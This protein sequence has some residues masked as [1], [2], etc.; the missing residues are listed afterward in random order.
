VIISG[1]AGRDYHNFLVYFKDN[2]KSEVVAFTQAQIPGIEKRSFPKELAGKL[3]KK[4][5][6][7]YPEEKLPELI[8]KYSV[9]EVVFSYSDVTHNQVMHLASIALANGADFR[10]LGPKSTMLKSKKLVISICAVRTGSGKSQTTRAI[11][12]ILKK[13]NKKVVSI[14]HPMP[15]GDLIKQKVQR[16][17]SEKDFKKY[18]TTIEEEE[19]YQPWI[20]NQ[21]VVYAGVDYKEILKQAE[22]EA[23][24]ILWDG[25]NNDLSFYHSDLHIV[26]ADPH[27]AGHELL[28]HPGETNFR[29]ADIILINKVD[30]ASKENIQLIKNNAKQYNS[31]AKIILARSDILVKSPEKIKNKRCLVVGDGPTLSH[32]GMSFGAGT[33]AVKK[34]QGKIV[35][36]RKYLVGSI[37]EAYKKYPN[38]QLELPAMG[39]SKK[40]IQELQTII[41]DTPCDL[42]VD[43]TPANLKRIIKTKKPI[44]EVNYELGNKAVKELTLMLKKLKFI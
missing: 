11:A 27:R 7:F 43:G 25:G 34:Y 37:K 39:Y 19:E 12:K 9:D 17:S 32:G 23:D 6:P 41:N 14:R 18:H 22:E 36:P 1:A 44:V 21:M 40:Q 8:K 2:P 5:I 10:L 31:K 20:D 26:V 28:Y 33:L 24:I 42:V 38:L 3:Y 4:D 13:N 29:M 15:Y 30:S 16:F 35:D